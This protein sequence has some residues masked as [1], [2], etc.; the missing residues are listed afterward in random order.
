MRFIRFSCIQ[1]SVG[2]L[3]VSVDVRSTLIVNGQLQE[4]I[5]ELFKR[6]ASFI[7]LTSV[8]TFSA[9]Y[10]LSRSTVALSTLFT[11]YDVLNA[12]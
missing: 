6:K 9:Y 11:L 7:L 2:I 4:G 3:Y 5:R 12:F 10:E 8:F 1:H